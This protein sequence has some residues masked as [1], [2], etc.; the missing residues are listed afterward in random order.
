MTKRARAPALTESLS[1]RISKADRAQ[2]ERLSSRVR[3]LKP[4]TLARIAL[5]IGLGMLERDPSAL[6]SLR[7]GT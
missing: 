6:L 1:M 7:G 4:V 5:T 2:L 3:A